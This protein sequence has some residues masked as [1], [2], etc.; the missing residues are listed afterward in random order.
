[1]TLCLLPQTYRALAQGIWLIAICVLGAAGATNLADAFCCLWTPFC[2][3]RTLHP[4]SNEGL[5]T[6]AGGQA[7]DWSVSL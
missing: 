2:F 6:A 3:L 4:G 7:T 1:M 5:L